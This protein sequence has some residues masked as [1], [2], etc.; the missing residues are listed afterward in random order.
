MNPF[1]KPIE[2][3]NRDY[4]IRRGTVEQVSTYISAMRNIPLGEAREF[5]TNKLKTP[6]ALPGF[7]NPTMTRLR[8]VSRG[9]REEEE[10]PFLNY[11]DE[12]IEG[13]LILSPSMVTY[14][15]PSVMRST[16]AVWQEEKIQSRRTSKSRM[17]TLQQAGDATGAQLANYEQNAKKI[18]INTVSG[19]RGFKGNPLFLTTGHSTLTSTCR[20]AAGYGNAVIERFISGARHYHEYEIAKANILA[21]VTAVD[22]DSIEKVINKYNLIY[23]TGEQAAEVVYRSTSLYVNNVEQDQLILDLLTNLTPLQRAAY[24]YTG[25]FYHVAKFNDGFARKFVNDFIMLDGLPDGIPDDLDADATL[26]T[27]SG[28]EEAY[29]NT[30]CMDILRGSTPRQV[31]K[32]NPEGYKLMAKTTYALKALLVEYSDFISHIL[33]TT[34]L[35]A[36]ISSLRSIQRRTSLAGDTD[37]AIF[38]CQ[39]WVMWYQD[40]LARTTMG[41]RVWYLITYM[42]CQC[43]ANAL[44]LLS[45]NIGVDD[46]HMFRLAMKNEYAF[47]EFALTSMAKNYF[48]TMSMREGNVFSKMEMEIKGVELRGS[49]IPAKTLKAV[50]SLMEEILHK[51]DKSEKIDE[52][53]ILERIAGYEKETVDSVLAGEYT[54]LTPGSIKAGT[55]REIHYDL[56]QEVFAPKYGDSIPPPYPT[57][58]IT[59]SLGNKTAITDFIAKVNET[60]PA[61]SKRLKDWII[62]RDRKNLNTI[63]LPAMVIRGKGIPKE[64]RHA[65]D[66][67]KLTYQINSSFY[68]IIET[69][70]LNVVDRDYHRLVSDY[71]GYDLFED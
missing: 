30:L 57:V 17:F 20:A 65:I 51:V 46:E 37:S 61:L 25:D 55:Q 16:T 44:A 56:W 40:H 26:K 47:P 5:V 2:E 18:R 31:K 10:L 8:K 64:L 38:T 36:S 48:S 69:L 49:K 14:L 21:V 29:L 33:A 50:D 54:F 43:I 22:L 71:L 35:P 15:P 45:A 68:R 39:E 7:T 11:I 1:V 34:H 6:G 24:C 9:K 67:R 32:E 41:D 4:N 62:S 59:T 42:G 60:D 58:T 63:M 53:E 52:Y 27:L 23:P 3:Y 28:T 19:M 70:G 12:A 66:L 13:G